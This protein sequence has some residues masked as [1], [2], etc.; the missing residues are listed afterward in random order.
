MALNSDLRPNYHR[1]KC[2]PS[3]KFQRSHHRADERVLVQEIFLPLER[4]TT[5]TWNETN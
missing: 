2:S 4:E 5:P 3:T 1:H